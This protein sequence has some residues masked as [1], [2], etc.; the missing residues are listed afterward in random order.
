M[1]DKLPCGGTLCWT[2]DQCFREILDV[3]Y[4]LE[5]VILFNK[6][7]QTAMVCNHSMPLGASR[8]PSCR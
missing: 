8:R 3:S 6:I 7:C 4:S 2:M 1:A 5:E